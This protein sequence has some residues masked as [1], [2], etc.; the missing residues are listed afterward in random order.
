MTVNAQAGKI[1]GKTIMIWVITLGLPALVLLMPRTEV[2]TG[3]IRLFLAITLMAILMFAFE[4]I[5]QTAVAIMLPLLY[6]VMNVAPSNVAFAP[7]TQTIP[8]MCIGGLVLANVLESTG[9]LKRV[10]FKSII[11]TG[12]SYSGILYGLGI[13][14]LVMNIFIPGQVTIPMAALSFGICTALNLGKS[15]EAAGIM[16]TAALGALIPLMFF[17]NPNYLVMVNAGKDVAGDLTPSWTNFFLT[18]CVSVIFMFVMIFIATK[19]FKPQQKISGKDYF[20][21]EYQ[22]LGKMSLEEKKGVLVCLVL[23]IFLLTGKMHGIDLGWGFALIPILLYCPGI[24]IGT[25]HDL[26]RVN[27]GFILFITA[28]MGIGA[29]AGHLGIGKIVAAVIMP[30]LVGKSTTFVLMF[31]WAVCVVLNFLL[32][33]LAI[34]GAFSGPIAQIAL[35]LGINPSAAYMV[36]YHG[37]DQIVMPYEYALYL[38]FFSFG[39]IHLKDFMKLMSIKLLINFIF[40]LA[41]L[42]PFWG[43]IG[44]L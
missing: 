14:G 1:N 25:A 21:K 27:Y 19:L 31:V 20:L 26:K 35:D 17:F 33:P 7:W 12:A 44:Y 37:C 16:L 3:E 18:N 8:W 36:M 2:F 28:C 43:L 32:T 22:G 9:L 5:Q 42:I 10:A 41:V 34:M 30:I 15:R 4:N 11:L 13:A 39:L 29:V 40:V 38:I 23:F 24:N 6:I